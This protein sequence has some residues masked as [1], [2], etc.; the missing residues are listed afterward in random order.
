MPFDEAAFL[1]SGRQAQPRQKA[2]QILAFLEADRAAIDFR[3]VADDRQAKTCSGLARRIETCPAGEE[4]AAPLLGD[5]RA[6]VLDQD[7]DEVAFGLDRHEHA[8]SAIFGGILDEVAEHF[9]K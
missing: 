2:A 5:A 1:S 8:S 3:D 6:V 4:L 7:V 9:V